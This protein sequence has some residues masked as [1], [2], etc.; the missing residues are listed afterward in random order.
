MTEPTTFTYTAEEIAHLHPLPALAEIV[1]DRVRWRL[2]RDLEYRL[3][4]RAEGEIGGA[5]GG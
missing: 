1:G 2:V 4:D 3:I 5:A